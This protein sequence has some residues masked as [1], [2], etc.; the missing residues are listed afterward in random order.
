MREI[1]RGQNIKE[2]SIKLKTPL[3]KN[4]RPLIQEQVLKF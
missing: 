1:E 2:Q 4:T 3:Y